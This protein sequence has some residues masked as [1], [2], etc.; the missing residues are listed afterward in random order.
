MV[1]AVAAAADPPQ[2][3]K[4]ADG[5]V[6]NADDKNPPGQ[7][8]NGGD[9]NHGYECDVKGQPNGGNNGVG[10]GNPAH[11]PCKPGSNSG[12][13]PDG[14]PMPPSGN[15][16]TTTQNCPDGTPMPASGTCGTTTAGCVTNCTTGSGGT[17]PAAVLGVSFSRPTEVLGVQVSRGAGLAF[18]GAATTPMVATALALVGMGLALV[19]ISRREE[20]ELITCASRLAG[21]VWG[22]GI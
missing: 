6:G 22:H 21:H 14:S 11:T 5:S 13:C 10:K 17:P 3:G 15:C 8:K 4:P 19:A 12:D 1:A 20:E 2:T 18:T 7:Y 16:D 9:A